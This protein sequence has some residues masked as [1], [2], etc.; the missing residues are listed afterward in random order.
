MVSGAY[1]TIAN[2]H[3]AK[4]TRRY[5]SREHWSKSIVT[6]T[7]KSSDVISVYRLVPDPALGLSREECEAEINAATQYLAGELRGQVRSTQWG[8]VIVSTPSAF[9]QDV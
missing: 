5:L 9:G 1:I 2:V 6:Q 8:G 4:L 7:H 3:R